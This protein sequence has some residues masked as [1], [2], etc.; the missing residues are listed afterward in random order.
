M[1]FVSRPFFGE[2]GKGERR[3]HRPSVGCTVGWLVGVY[4]YYYYLKCTYL[5]DNVTQNAAGA[6]YTVN[7]VPVY[8]I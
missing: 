4:Y 6:L 1:L 2:F 7:K 5:S 8:N 3:D